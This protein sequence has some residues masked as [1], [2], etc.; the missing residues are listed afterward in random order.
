MSCNK[1]KFL[2]DLPQHKWFPPINICDCPRQDD[3]PEFNG[4]RKVILEK[5]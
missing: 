3:L 5:N 1:D 4:Q 2:Q